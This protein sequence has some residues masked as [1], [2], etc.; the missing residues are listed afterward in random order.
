MTAYAFNDRNFAFEVFA[1]EIVILNVTEG[2]YFAV[3]GWAVEIW[4]NLAQGGSTERIVSDVSSHYGI[5]TS[6][7]GRELAEFVARLKQE[8][9]F[10]DAAPGD[11]ADMAMALSAAFQP[12][13]FEKHID[14]QDLLTLDPIH[15][16]DPKKGWPIQS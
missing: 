11:G 14:M 13:S 12:I 5:P 15:D 1:D 9:I 16:V 2:T 8:S 4:N 3:G 10:H 7:V 6:E